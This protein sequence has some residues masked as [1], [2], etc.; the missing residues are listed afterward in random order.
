VLSG[1]EILELQ[2]VVRRV[3]V[4]DHVLRYVLRLVRAT[5]AGTDEAPEFV[6][7][8]VAWGAGP[9]ASQYLVLAA[10]ARALLQGRLYVSTDDVRAVAHPVLRHRVITTYG[11][12]AEGYTSDR[13]V[14]ELLKTVPAAE[15]EALRDER[16]PSVLGS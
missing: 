5:R 4:P 11:A 15:S 14:D 13:L 7:D 3:P 12:E 6:R 2:E 1:A 8:R 16:L 10:K 9:R